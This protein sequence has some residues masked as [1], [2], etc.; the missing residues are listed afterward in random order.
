[1]FPL[2]LTVAQ[3]NNS[4]VARII[5]EDI[6]KTFPTAA[7]KSVAAVANVSLSIAAGELVTIV[8]PSGSGKTTLLRLLA[9]LEQPDFGRI[10]I[11]AQDVTHLKPQQRD[12]AMVFQSPALLPH[13]TGFENL[14]FGLRLRRVPA[15]EIK[16]RVQTMAALLH[17][18]HCLDRPPAKLSGGECQRLALGRALIRRPKILL[19]DEPFAHLD[20]NLRT[21]LR[22]ELPALQQHF[23]TTILFVTHDQAEA[24]ALGHRVAVLRHGALQQFAPPQVV[25]EHPA[26]RFVASFIGTPPLTLWHGTVAQ[27]DGHLVFVGS[28][29]DSNAAPQLVL[30][31]GSERAAWFGSNVNRQ[32]LLGFR[33]EQVRLAAAEASPPAISA[34]VQSVQFTG[35]DEFVHLTVAGRALV[36]RAQPRAAFAPGQQ[37]SVTFDWQ[38]AR[39]FDAATGAAL[40]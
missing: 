21:Q 2:D 19:L 31:I 26:N 37:L 5:V 16:A 38:H 11:D 10:L 8:G 15:S 12:V 3:T 9:G 39:V 23:S 29:T 22:Q 7:G 34:I 17:V 33:P 13:F 18:S 6:R 32:I 36:S 40:A 28:E 25:Y 24:L 35:A 14:A 4:A 1:M 27:R 20:E 30:P